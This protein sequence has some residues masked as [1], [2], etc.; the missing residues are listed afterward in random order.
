MKRR[1]QR[2]FPIWRLVVVSGLCLA[3]SILYNTL[4]NLQDDKGRK[5]EDIILESMNKKS[6]SREP[7]QSL[8]DS[9]RNEN[10]AG[11]GAETRQDRQ[12]SL[13]GESGAIADAECEAFLD[14]LKGSS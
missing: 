7:S 9:S 8:A 10:I 4:P 1:K 2:A 6:G 5:A 3:L 14:L 11:G 12:P 13:G